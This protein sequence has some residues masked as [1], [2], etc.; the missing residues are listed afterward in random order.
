MSTKDIGLGS[1]ASLTST[2]FSG[3]AGSLNKSIAA[4]DLT[5][6]GVTIRASAATDDLL[7]SS[8]KSSSA[9]AKVAAINAS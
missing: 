4:G 2:A 8:D 3:T 7:S 1:R 6:N 5:I 9:I